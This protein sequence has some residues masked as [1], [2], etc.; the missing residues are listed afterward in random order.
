MVEQALREARSWVGKVTGV[1]MVG[2]GQAEDGSATIDVWVDHEVTL[3]RRVRGVAVRVRRAGA[4][5]AQ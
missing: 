3:P 1:V 2:Q 5:E 4:I